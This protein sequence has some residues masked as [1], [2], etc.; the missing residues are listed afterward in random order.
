MVLVIWECF[1]L[2]IICRALEERLT[3]LV[4]V[5]EELE[6]TI[7]EK[8]DLT[9]ENSN[10]KACH[11]THCMKRMYTIF[12]FEEDD[13]DMIEHA[14]WPYTTVCTNV[15]SESSELTLLLSWNSCIFCANIQMS[16]FTLLVPFFFF[17]SSLLL[18]PIKSQLSI[19]TSALAHCQDSL[20][21]SQDT[22]KSLQELVARQQDELHCGEMER[23]KLHNT[24]QELKVR[25][26][27]YCR[28][29]VLKHS[30]TRLNAYWNQ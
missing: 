6:R 15:S 1:A 23:R 14:F 7:K 17:F 25:W 2:N 27:A 3:N 21:V 20:R 12:F 19:Q 26:M 28:S 29:S 13:A 5:K 30:N 16:L 18:F 8:D 4:S 9:T 22:V 10:I 11:C 24:I